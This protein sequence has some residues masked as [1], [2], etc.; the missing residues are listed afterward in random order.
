MGGGWEGQS[1]VT[2]LRQE[3]AWQRGTPK[4][5]VEEAAAG[6]A[7][8]GNGGLSRMW[9]AQTQVAALGW[10]KAQTQKVESPGLG[11]SRATVGGRT[12]AHLGV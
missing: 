10:E 4:G 1:C 8:A 5:P 2:A 12:T 3:W 7:H 9:A 11:G 6:R